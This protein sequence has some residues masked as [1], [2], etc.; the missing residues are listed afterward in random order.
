MTLLA[1]I[2]VKGGF[3][4][5]R[6]FKD[7]LSFLRLNKKHHCVLLED[8]PVNTG[9]IKHVREWVTWGEI[10]ELTLK[11]LISKRGRLS[12]GKRVEL[13]EKELDKLVKDLLNGKGSLNG[14]KPVF[15]LS[16]PKKGWDK[17]T[18]KL[19]YP[20]GALGPRGKAINSLLKRMI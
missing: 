20:N 14:I 15:R 1:V 18:I 4:I 19:Q 16:P 9:M 7:T 8:N 10:D 17:G 12:G 6:G 2:R 3:K 13:K 5:R 11:K